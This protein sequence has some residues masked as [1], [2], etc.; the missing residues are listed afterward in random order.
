MLKL[1]FFTG[2]KYSEAWSVVNHCIFSKSQWFHCISTVFPLYVFAVH[3]WYKKVPLFFWF[4]HQGR[5]CQNFSLLFWS[6]RF[7]P[8]GV[9]KLTDLYKQG[10]LRPL[11][12][13][14]LYVNR[15]FKILFL[16]SIWDFLA[17]FFKPVFITGIFVVYFKKQTDII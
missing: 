3:N 13:V 16:N 7:F 1:Q 12:N 10:H 6:K 5:N 2:K 17:C 9:L 14:T 8:K 4:D 11:S 15:F